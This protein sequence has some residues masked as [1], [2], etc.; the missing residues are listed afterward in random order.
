M[1]TMDGLG[2]AKAGVECG[3]TD[4]DTLTLELM[5]NIRRPRLAL[6]LRLRR[7]FLR[8]VAGERTFLID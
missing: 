8:R 6:W 3:D 1:K 4:L 2:A 5:G 7:L